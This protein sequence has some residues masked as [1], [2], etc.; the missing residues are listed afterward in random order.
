VLSNISKVVE[1]PSREFIKDL[2]VLTLWRVA[3]FLHKVVS[4]AEG[5]ALY[6]HIPVHIPNIEREVAP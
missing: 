1:V 2:L 6:A 4:D 3:V 5:K